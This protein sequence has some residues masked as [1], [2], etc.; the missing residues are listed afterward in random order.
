MRKTEEIKADIDK[1]SAEIEDLTKKRNILTVE[2]AY[3]FMHLPLP[4]GARPAGKLHSI[5]DMSGS[6]AREE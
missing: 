2:L 3:S 6:G 5:I 4:E 1:I